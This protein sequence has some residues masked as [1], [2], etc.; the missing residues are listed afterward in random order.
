LPPEEKKIRKK[1]TRK[2]A[3][4]RDKK[5]VLKNSVFSP[6]LKEERESY[7]FSGG[8]LHQLEIL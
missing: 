7:S 2:K 6:R 3:K 8:Q 1:T 4:S 5:K